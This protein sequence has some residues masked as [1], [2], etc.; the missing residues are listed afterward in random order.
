MLCTWQRLLLQVGGPQASEV[1]SSITLA[2]TFQMKWCI[3]FIRIMVI[4][5]SWIWPISSISI[6]S[7]TILAFFAITAAR[8]AAHIILAHL[9]LMSMLWEEPNLFELVIFC[10]FIAKFILNFFVWQNMQYFSTERHSTRCIK[11]FY[12]IYLAGVRPLW[13]CSVSSDAIHSFSYPSLNKT[14][15]LQSFISWIVP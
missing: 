6:A 11:T 14:T 9:F 4:I 7:I 3:H 1:E 8:I 12:P 2:R 10:L 5:V 15:Y 13:L